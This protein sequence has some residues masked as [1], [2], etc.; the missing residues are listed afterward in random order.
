M[1]YE[2]TMGHLGV[3]MKQERNEL[4]ETMRK[5]QLNE[6]GR[7]YQDNLGNIEAAEGMKSRKKAVELGRGTCFL[8]GF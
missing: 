8:L 5:S 2:A 7:S 4:V 3:P 6:G 1:G